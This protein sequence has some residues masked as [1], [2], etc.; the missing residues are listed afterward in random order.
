MAQYNGNRLI[1]K[2][3]ETQARFLQRG[4]TKHP[5]EH[6]HAHAK[7]G[8]LLCLLFARIKK[9]GRFLCKKQ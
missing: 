9:I 7:R 2:K 8:H 4:T 1:H 3:E 6:K 5:Y